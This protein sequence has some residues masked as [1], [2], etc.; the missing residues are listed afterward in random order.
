MILTRDELRALTGRKAKKLMPKELVAL[1][2][3]FE[4][5][6]DGWP[7]VLRTHVEQVLSGRTTVRRKTRPNFE[8]IEA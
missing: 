4:I 6:T 5:G 8:G 7:R 3:H 1:G 2:I